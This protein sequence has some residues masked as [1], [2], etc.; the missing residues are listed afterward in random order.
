MVKGRAVQYR[1]GPKVDASGTF[2]GDLKFAGFTEFQSH[3]ARQPETLTRALA[4]K[5]LTFAT[6]RELG[7]SDRTE[8]ERIVKESAR[9]GYRVRDL[10]HLVISSK[11]FQ[12]K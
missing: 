7:F 5:L 4:K 3:L 6:G 8:L 10:I 1:Q 11:I 12:S 2:E 9:T